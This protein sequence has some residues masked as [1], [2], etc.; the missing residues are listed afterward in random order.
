MS[1]GGPWDADPFYYAKLEGGQRVSYWIEFGCKEECEHVGDCYRDDVDC[2]LCEISRLT[3]A[4]ESA[5]AENERLEDNLVIAEANYSAS[6]DAN[7]RIEEERDDLLMCNDFV[8]KNI[9]GLRT[10]RDALRAAAKGVARHLGGDHH[11]T[12]FELEAALKTT[13]TIYCCIYTGEEC[14]CRDANGLPAKMCP[15]LKTTEG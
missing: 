15:K 9:E 2:P 1:I 14:T 5:Q 13:D 6:V 8:G 12:I 10:E 4:L 7:I 11:W 3:Q